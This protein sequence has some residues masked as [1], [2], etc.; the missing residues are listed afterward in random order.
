MLL[1]LSQT[2]PETVGMICVNRPVTLD[3]TPWK[4]PRKFWTGIWRTRLQ[5]EG[6]GHPWILT[7]RILSHDLV[8]DYFPPAVRVNRWLMAGQLKR[9]L[10]EVYPTANAAIQWIYHP[11]QRW[12]FAALPTAGKIYECFDNYSRSP[13]GVF[14]GRTWRDEQQTLQSVALTFVT[15]PGLMHTRQ[16]LTSRLEL[17]PNGVPDFFFSEAPMLPSEIDRV[18]RPRIGYLGNARSILDFGLLE[19]VFRTR[20]DWS[21][22]F[23]GPVER[24]AAVADLR[25][26]PNVYFLGARPH[27][28]IPGILRRFDVGL[29]PFRDNEFTRVMSTLKLCEYLAAGV[30]VVA[31][32]LPELRRFSNV[33]RLVPGES[34]PFE[35]A[36]SETLSLDRSVLSP[37]LSA[38]ARPYSWRAIC[39]R[40][41]IPALQEVFHL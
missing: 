11:K 1:A 39:Q 10:S 16:L 26:L 41:V 3:V 38:A 4:R 17:L 32:D 36:I 29:I 20:R 15:T 8:A 31:T 37:V 35:K 5:S 6:D 12:V 28:T 9:A 18:P 34:V 21:L 19:Q 14:D 33:L 23:L 13:L 40:H 24:R 22:V 25:A 7:P 27:E 2:L 30:P